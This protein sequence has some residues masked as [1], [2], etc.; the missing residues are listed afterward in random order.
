MLADLRLAG[1]SLLKSPRFSAVVIVT[2]ALCIG[3]NTA[4]FSVV[5]SV[6]LRPL[7]YAEPERLVHLWMENRAS[8]NRADAASWPLASHWRERG[9][10]LAAIAGYT[11]ST[12]YN[13][14]GDGEPARLAGTIVSARFFETLGV[15]PAL[16]RTF[17]D[18]EQTPGQD[19]VVI[20]G[21]RF[22][23]SRYAGDPA[24]VGREMTLNGA[25]RTV[26][27]VMPAGFEF[28]GR[29]DIYLPVA[30]SPQ[31]IESPRANFLLWLGRL[32]PGVAIATA[33]AELSAAQPAFWERFPDFK[34]QGVHV[35]GLHEW[36]VREV[37]RALWILLGAVFCVLLI[38]CANLANL[39]L[40]RG[41]ARRHELAVHVALGASPGRLTRRILAE[42]LL[43]SLTGGAAGALLGVYGVDLIRLIA[44]EALPRADQL[45]VDAPV[46]WATGG[47]A[48]LCGVFF[49]FAPAWQAGRV[50][51]QEALKDG[52]RGASGS[53][54]S[55]RLRSLLV[56]GQSALAFLL[57]FGAG[58]LLRSLW[59]LA[60]VDTG[61]RGENLISIAVALPRA[62]Y[63]TL[64]KL[65]AFQEQALEQLR[66][67]PGV[68]SAAFT[69]FI[70]LN[71]LHGSARLTLEGGAG[72]PAA[73]LEATI[74]I[75]SAGYFA[76]MGVPLVAGRAFDATD[77]PDGPLAVIVNE[78]LARTQ[79]PGRDPL[80]Q[81]FL[82]GEPPA[83][84][85]RDA[86]G[87]PILPRWLTVVGIVR[88]LHRDGPDRPVR[89]QL[90]LA[91]SQNPPLNFRFVVR[92][93]QPAPAIAASLRAAIWSVDRNLPL[94]I[95]EPLEVMLERPTAS[96]R[97][98]L[99]LFGSFAGLALLLASLGL[100]G[101]MA[102]SVGQR[103]VEFGI[104]LALGAR[105]RELERLV[106]ADGVVLV[107]AGIALGG[108]AS[109]GL[110]RLA[111]SLLY[112][113]GTLDWAALAAALLV[114][115]AAALAACWLPAR[116][117]ARVDPMVALRAE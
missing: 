20:L 96:R 22:W 52:A 99:W 60:A 109:L 58:L 116:R 86:N 55:R 35:A 90:F 79:W 87:Q 61:L 41:L 27:G 72:D 91:A 117:A 69:T 98:N 114:L 17:T 111:E 36:S 66:A 57:L 50:A 88:D 47:A 67:V 28:P 113:V 107:G 97:L 94:P 23:Q 51:P 105:G 108:A 38:G 76:T 43:L 100:Y 81:R 4:L 18:V 40:V 42:S 54:V 53:R 14:T 85:A 2:F 5:R 15:S 75:V 82:L 80:G 104:R 93:T 65:A 77:R 115:L 112:G 9:T 70:L 16:G 39:L 7:P 44:G 59:K 74:D 49:G 103:T 8:G 13:L 106:L 21:H 102:Y 32:K 10:S 11:T 84:G 95:V 83:P 30:A 24:V 64:P 63:D 48:V 46:L 71:R 31:Q 25:K 1:R 56:I 19:A 110:G 92:T 34:H 6:L 37:R 26:V 89:R 62:H 12:A 29:T 33:Q 73:R 101:V 78:T 68:D 3:A 45:A